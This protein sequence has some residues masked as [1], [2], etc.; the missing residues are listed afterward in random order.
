MK[1]FAVFRQ[2]LD[3]FPK[4]H[5][6]L[7]VGG[8][9][10]FW[11]T[12]GFEERDDIHIVLL[13]L[14]E[15]P[16]N[17]PM[18]TSMVGDATDLSRFNDQEFDIVFSNSVIEHVGGDWEQQKMA[19]EVMRVGK[20]YFV[21][22]PNLYFPI[23]PHSCMPLFQFLPLRLQVLLLYYFDLTGGGIQRTI[24]AW[25]ARL[26][27]RRFERLPCESWERCVARVKALRLLSGRKFHKMFPGSRMYRE[28]CLGLTKSFILYTNPST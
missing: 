2:W 11:K 20:A 17:S 8:T 24:Q 13:N 19:N 16:V 7:D 22:T 9:N 6:I 10:A 4:P 3:Q 28:K 15:N 1:R 27:F 21:Q 26:T 12:M 18:F 5:K 23:E 14:E 25:K